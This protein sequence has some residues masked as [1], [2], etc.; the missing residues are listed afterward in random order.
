MRPLFYLC[1]FF[2]FVACQSADDDCCELPTPAL[3][4]LSSQPVTLE[5]SDRT[6]EYAFIESYNAVSTLTFTANSD[7]A[8]LEI[9][10]FDQND[11]ERVRLSGAFSLIESVGTPPAN[12]DPTVMRNQFRYPINL[13]F[14]VE[15]TRA[16]GQRCR[17]GPVDGQITNWNISEILTGTLTARATT[18]ACPLDDTGLQGGS[19]RAGVVIHQR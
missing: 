1:A 5:L 15:R 9:V 14:T 17:Y 2:A 12:G 8:R 3:L 13:T 4:P 6:R 18:S 16:D 19:F 7:T 10:R 11:G